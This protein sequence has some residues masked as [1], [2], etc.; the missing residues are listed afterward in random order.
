LKGLKWKCYIEASLKH[1]LMFCLFPSPEPCSPTNVSSQLVC[2]AGIA[3]VSWAPSANAVKYAMK[4]TSNEQI[5][6]CTSS[7][8]NCTL[9]DLVCG[10]LYDIVVTSTDGT[11]V[12]GYSAAFRQ[13][14]GT[15]R[16]VVPHLI[17]H[18]LTMTMAK[19]TNVTTNLLCGTSDMTVSWI[20]NALPF[21][22]S[23]IAV[24]LA[25]N[26]SSVTCKT[27]H[28]N[29]SLSGLQCG[30]TYNVSVKA[31]SGSCSGP[32]S[33]PQIVQTGC[34]YIFLY[35]RDVFS[36]PL[37][38]GPCDP[39][40]VTSIY[41]CG[42][43]KAT[44]S[45][46]AAAGAVAYTVHA[47]EG[48]SQHY[49]SCRSN[50]TSCQLNQL[51]CGK[52]YNLTVMAEDATCNSTGDIS[53]TLMT[54][55]CSPSV[56]NSTLICGTN[57]SSLS[58]M[59]MAD[60]TG[61][62]V[63]AT[64]TNG[65]TVSCS[66]AAATCILTDLLCSETYMTT[67]TAQG[68]QCDS[69][70]SSST[71]I[72]TSPCA[73]ANISKQ[74]VC[75]TSTAVFSWTD[76]LGRLSF[77]AQVAGEGYQDSCQTTNTSCAFQS[78]PCGLGLNVTVE[79]QGAQCNS[80]P[81]VS[82]SLETGNTSTSVL[83]ILVC[84]NHSALVSWVGSPSAIGFNVTLTGQDGHTHHCQTNTTSCQL[85][86]IHCGETYDIVVTP[87]SETCAG[88]PSALYVFRAGTC[89]TCGIKYTYISP[90]RD[91]YKPFFSLLLSRSL[92]SQ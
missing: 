44:V 4:A 63:N 82:E 26:I 80:I 16:E 56:Q 15:E 81:S 67:V 37:P 6:S 60:A 54:A 11:C 23:V 90:Q 3:H 24:P 76:P 14:E 51:Q 34:V 20:P 47:Q 2:S 64:A 92:C 59:A 46:E 18:L 39:V 88:H 42:S 77:L 52:V 32:Y 7:T 9:T 57:S 75:G 87:Y 72:T 1:W 41:Q 33:H 79:A 8:P 50:T 85:P 5:L 30:Q 48:S 31:S 74:Y 69:A 70:P 13:D 83:A 29:C 58:W 71:N 36:L 17:T 66:S 55:P 61:Y 86:D 22:Y 43:D 89:S 53:T 38:T 62:I 84:L 68:S 27:S 25:G 45:W 73:P 65:H 40:N 19:K 21:N 35:E 78:L 49:S 12:S 28:A 91:N 10:Q